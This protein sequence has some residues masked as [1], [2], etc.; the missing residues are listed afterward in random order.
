M[1][2]YEFPPLGGGAGVACAAMLN[3]MKTVQDLQ[4]DLITSSAH[5]YSIIELSPN[6]RI[7]FL[8][9]HKGAQMHYQSIREL[10][11]Y[12]WKSYWYAKKLIKGN[13]FGLCHAFFGI[14]CGFVAMQLGLPYIVSIR[15][16]DIPFH[17]PRFRWLDCVLFKN[18]SLKIWRRARTVIVNSLGMQNEIHAI[19]SALKTVIITNGV[20]VKLFSPPH[21][22][23]NNRVLTMV[24]VGRL[25]SVKNHDLLLCA[26]R[27]L[28]DV[29]LRIVGDG[30]LRKSLEGHSAELNCNVEFL[31]NR[32]RE[33]IPNL[34]RSGNL[35]VL[36]SLNEGMPN[37][38][39]EAMACGL[40]VIMTDVGGSDE[41]IDGNGFVVP[42][43]DLVALRKA[44]EQYIKKPSLLIRHGKRSMEI[45]ETMSWKKVADQYLQLYE[46]IIRS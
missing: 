4:I 8:N 20:N 17:N 16:G 35:F 23:R 38:V 27:D 39:L 40:P 28:P 44:I 46:K 9:I 25:I 22:S 41:L 12:A 7:H 24:S 14:P 1:L 29:R 30:P 42:K 33:S 21:L 36:P 11:T 3:K 10:L 32:Q 15:G 6:I 18:L 26:L 34:L 13:Q 43:N 31:G 19:A 2:N 37:A 5:E 45:A